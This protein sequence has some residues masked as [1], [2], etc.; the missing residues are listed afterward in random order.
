MLRR[1]RHLYQ[2]MLVWNCYT[3]LRAKTFIQ[4]F[5]SLGL[6]LSYDRCLSIC[7][8]IGL[9]ILKKYDLELVFVASHLIHETFAIIAKDNIDLNAIYFSGISMTTMQFPS[10]ENQGVK[11]NVIC[12]LSLLDNSKKLALPVDY[13]II[14]E[15]PYRKNT[16]L[17]LTVC[18]IN[19]EYLNYQ[20]TFCKTEFVKWIACWNHLIQKIYHDLIPFQQF[21]M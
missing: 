9:N 1:E 12:D 10:K 8:N 11:Q 17:S 16:P 14:S 4:R 20:D 7:N 18:T 5:F 21:D 13:E 2:I 19:R 6:P 3:S 15:L